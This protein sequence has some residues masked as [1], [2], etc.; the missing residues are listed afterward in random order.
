MEV[1]SWISGRDFTWRMNLIPCNSHIRIVKLWYK[2][3]DIVSTQYIKYLNRIFV[4]ILRLKLVSRN[5]GRF[6]PSN[7]IQNTQEYILVFNYWIYNISIYLGYILIIFY[8]LSFWVGWIFFF[9]RSNR[10]SWHMKIIKQIKKIKKEN[11][12]KLRWV[13][14]LRSHK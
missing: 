4:W 8:I 14:H 2:I 12:E 1:K 9:T 10:M 7:I 3:W 11:V 6:L 5:F 13:S